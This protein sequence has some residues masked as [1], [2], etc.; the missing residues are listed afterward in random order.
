MKTRG[1]GCTDHT[2]YFS[3][4]LTNWVKEVATSFLADTGAVAAAIT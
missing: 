3:T 4:S 2:F 1:L